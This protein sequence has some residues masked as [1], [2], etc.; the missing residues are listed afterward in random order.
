M[1]VIV[2]VVVVVVTSFLGGSEREMEIERMDSSCQPVICHHHMVAC[3]LKTQRA[4]ESGSG[5]A[6]FTF[7]L[8]SPY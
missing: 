5:K 6:D 4:K 3:A 2:V 1:V 7:L 8:Q